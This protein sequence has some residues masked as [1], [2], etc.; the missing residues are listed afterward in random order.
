[1]TMAQAAMYVHSD[2]AVVAA[3][4]AVITGIATAK[5]GSDSAG[6]SE[7][8]VTLLVVKLLHQKETM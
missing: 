5:V 2:F 7:C 8:E 1:V 4:V 3:A 6:L